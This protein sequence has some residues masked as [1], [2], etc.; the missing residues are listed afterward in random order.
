[1]NKY[2]EMAMTFSRRHRPLAFAELAQPDEFFTAMGEEIAAEVRTLTSELQHRSS[3]T[4]MTEDQARL[5]AEE[6][7]LAD[8][9]LLI[10]EPEAEDDLTQDDDPAV[11]QHYRDLAEINAS[12][13]Q[14]W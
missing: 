12:I 2:G 9:W 13:H 10:P 1:M 3:G 14:D 6:I 11:A 5:A 4:A 8:H 7:V